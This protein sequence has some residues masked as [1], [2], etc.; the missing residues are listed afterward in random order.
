[1]RLL[2]ALSLSLLALSASPAAAAD[3][4]R[5]AI[6]L[7]AQRGALADM[8]QPSEAM[9]DRAGSPEYDWM[10]RG[11][12]RLG[13]KPG[14]LRMILPW[15]VIMATPDNRVD[16]AR[17]EL[18][19]PQ[20]L[21]LSRTTGE[22]RRLLAS[23]AVEGGYYAHDMVT[24]IKDLPVETDGGGSAIEADGRLVAHF[25]PQTRRQPIDP[26]DV[27]GLLVSIEA[28]ID[29]ADYAAGADYVMNVAADYW[30]DEKAKWDNYKSG[31]DAAVS[32]MKRLTPEWRT[33]Y[34]TT[35]DAAALGRCVAP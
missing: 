27:A 32:R 16:H 15:S 12:V 20:L 1:M 28:R 25:W 3:A 24:K 29:P 18:R 8:A 26:Q 30:L 5:S 31:S 6:P 19:N 9:P 33:F 11:R 14:R 7:A 35:A 34:M 4:C 13:N 23:D 17:V 2:A 22:W 21:V 10:S